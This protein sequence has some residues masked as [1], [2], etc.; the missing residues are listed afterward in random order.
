MVNWSVSESKTNAQT[1]SLD[2]IPWNL[3]YLLKCEPITPFGVREKE[4]VLLFHFNKR[5]LMPSCE[6]LKF[7][8][9]AS[10][11]PHISLWDKIWV[12]IKDMGMTKTMAAR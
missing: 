11:E 12:G 1:T 4:V 3:E 7:Q 2:H 9:D 5:N 6:H 8:N 10:L